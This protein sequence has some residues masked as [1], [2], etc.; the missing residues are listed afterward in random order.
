MPSLG[1]SGR[2]VLGTHQRVLD[3]HRGAV[4][5]TS[6]RCVEQPAIASDRVHSYAV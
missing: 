6:G 5:I 1:R 2:A 4:L 3:D